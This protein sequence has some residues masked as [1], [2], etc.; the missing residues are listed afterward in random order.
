M[1]R[2]R[3]NEDFEIFLQHRMVR[4]WTG[5]PAGAKVAVVRGVI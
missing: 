3:R 4:E 5:A 1:R 2:P